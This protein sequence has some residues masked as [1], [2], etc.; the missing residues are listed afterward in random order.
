MEHWA[1]ARM[2][3]I[4]R[5]L[6]FHFVLLDA[7]DI[8]TIEMRAMRCSIALFSFYAVYYFTGRLYMLT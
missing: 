3:S 2:R 6:Y 8:A 7:F 5:L 4:A 1:A